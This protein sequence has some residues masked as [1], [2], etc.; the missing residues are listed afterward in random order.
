MEPKEII[1]IV[2]QL[3]AG[4]IA[5]FTAIM[6]WSQTRDIEWML[7][8]IGVIL[9]YV[10]IIVSSFSLLGIIQPEIFLI[11]GILDIGTVL[12]LLPLLFYSSAF[13]IRLV[14]IKN[15]TEY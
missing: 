14:K 4:A 13:I 11:Q 6:L 1:M 12:K 5:T 10:E 3:A 2:S 7:V 9:K 15:G 8:I